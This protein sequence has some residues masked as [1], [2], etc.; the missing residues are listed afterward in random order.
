MGG[1]ISRT[2]QLGCGQ[3]LHHLYFICQDEWWWESNLRLLWVTCVD[4]RTAHL[5]PELL[6]AQPGGL[7]ANYRGVLHDSHSRTRTVW[8]QGSQTEGDPADSVHPVST[9]KRHAWSGQ[10]HNAPF[11]FAC[12]FCCYKANHGITIH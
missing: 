2:K 8:E 5:V 3:P 4:R 6:S 10:L 9:I 7:Q 11:H 1:E 12:K